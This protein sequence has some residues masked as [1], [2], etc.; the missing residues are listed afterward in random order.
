M[1][2]LTLS[3]STWKMQ[4]KLVARLDLSLTL[5][6][7]SPS[8]M[9][10]STRLESLLPRVLS[11]VELRLDEAGHLHEQEVL[12]ELVKTLLG[13]CNWSMVRTEN[14]DWL[15]SSYRTQSLGGAGGRLGLMVFL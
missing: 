10:M 13:S 3:L 11:M 12:L 2:M 8:H 1:N 14:C 15:Q 7:F 6:T 5:T 4:L 9:L